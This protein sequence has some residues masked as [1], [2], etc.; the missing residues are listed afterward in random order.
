MNEREHRIL[1]THVGS[2]IR[3]PELI[4]YYQAMERAL[5]GGPPVDAAAFEQCVRDSVAQVVRQQAEAGVD[6]VSD[7]EFSKSWLWA[8]YTIDRL[9]GLEHRELD[10]G[11]AFFSPIHGKDR[12]DFAEFYAEYDK[13]RVFF[14][15]NRSRTRRWTVT[16]PLRYT[17]QAAVARD[18]TN[19]RDALR[20]VTVAGG[21]LTAVAPG[22]MLPERADV[23]YR[24]EEEGLFAVAEALREEYRAIVDA[25][26]ILQI[27]D[28]YL[29]S[30]YDMT[31]SA[32]GS[33]DDYRK[34]ATVRIDALNHALEGIP[35]ER[36]RCHV[37]WGSWNG[38]HTTDVPLRAIAD[39]LLRIK[40]GGY[41]LEMA[42]ARHE[43]EWRVWADV[44]L[45]EGKTL[46]PGVVGHQ[47]NV[48]EHPELVAERIV[49]LA[50]LVGRENVIAG[51]DC[52]FSPGPFQAR[53]HVSIQWAKLRSLA[54]GAQ[55]A[56]RELWGRAAA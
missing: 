47:T 2:L 38:P 25:G 55:L 17:G 15:R 9:S 26:Y 54:E 44:K 51:T 28:A 52:G 14:G 23:Y 49:R 21:F 13:S 45:P 6:L 12:R 40:T 37:C 42:N 48:V 8:N 5:D 24:T 35:E 33:L 11:D 53:F 43:H 41:V 20:G 3:P 7:G 27:D 1:T 19:F 46:V 18:L 16:G 10:P 30:W 22:S 39:L 31:L 32:G 36:T 29:A 34:W 50:K 56:T 4:A